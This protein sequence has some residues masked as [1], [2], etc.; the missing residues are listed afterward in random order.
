LAIFDQ[1]PKLAMSPRRA[2]F[3]L[4]CG[5]TYMPHLTVPGE[6]RRRAAALPDAGAW[7]D[8]PRRRAASWCAGPPALAA[9]EPTYAHHYPHFTPASSRCALL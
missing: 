6:K 7:T 4:D 3:G 8:D 2:G 9:D 1:L 5:S